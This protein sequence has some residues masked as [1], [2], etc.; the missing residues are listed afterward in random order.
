MHGRLN[1]MGVQ[2]SKYGTHAYIPYATD[3][4]NK[5]YTIHIIA[6]DLQQNQH[7]IYAI[8]RQNIFSIIALYSRSYQIEIY[9]TSVYTF[10]GIS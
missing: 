3:Q 7:Y 4:R 8:H 2:S 10:A 9:V 6:M 5:G 1:E